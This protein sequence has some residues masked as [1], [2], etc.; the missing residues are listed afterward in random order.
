M[1]N[2]IDILDLSV[3]EIDGLISTANDI[4]E[5]PGKYAKACEG[6]ILATLFFEPSTRTRL[7]LNP[8]CS[9][10]AAAFSDFLKQEALP[11]Q[12]A[13]AVPIPFAPLTAT[14]I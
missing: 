9:I 6:K 7:S 3:E 14:R 13:K 10:S 5:N 4:I 8:Q 2:L 11:L 12:K 1:S